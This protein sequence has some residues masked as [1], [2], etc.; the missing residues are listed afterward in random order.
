[1]GSNPG[2]FIAQLIDIYWVIVLI[3]VITSWLQLPPT[4]PIVQF[5]RALTEP[6]LAPIRKLLPPAG[7]LDF[8]P[9]I[10]LIGLRLLRG[11]FV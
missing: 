6:A 1:M 2:L 11:F 10:L 8:S 9:L 4:N 5:T 3:A 7:G